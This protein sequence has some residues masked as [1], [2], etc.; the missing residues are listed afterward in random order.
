MQYRFFPAVE[1]V[2]E[3][4]GAILNHNMMNCYRRLRGAMSLETINFDLAMARESVAMVMIML[5]FDD[6]EDS[7]SRAIQHGSLDLGAFK[8]DP[9]GSVPGLHHQPSG[10]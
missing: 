7:V 10:L 3:A 5:D 9:L 4:I 8:S 2:K 6:P 1:G